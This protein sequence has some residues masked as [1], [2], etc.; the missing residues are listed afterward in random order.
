MDTVEQYR[1]IIRE[2]LTKQAHPY[3]YSDEVEPEIICDPEHELS[4]YLRGWG[5]Q[6]ANFEYAL[7]F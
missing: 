3:T 5:R 7:P 4:A 2:V 6:Q 1:E